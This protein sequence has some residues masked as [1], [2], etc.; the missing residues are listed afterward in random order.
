MSI[1]GVGTATSRPSS[2]TDATR[3]SI[4]IGRPRSRSCSIEVLWAP[5]APAASM[6]RSTSIGKANPE[7]PGDRL[8]LDHHGAGHGA[9]SGVGDDLVRGLP[10]VSAEIGLKERLPQSLTQMSLRMLART[11]ALSPA[12]ASAVGETD[13]PRAPLARGLAE[14]EPVAF[15]VAD[16]AR[17]RDLGGGIDDAAD[18]PVRSDARPRCT[19][20]GSTLRCAVPRAARR[21]DGNTTRAGRSAR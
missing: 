12:A 7:R 5:T 13:D 20:P 2:C 11:G 18:R 19:P 6:R 4:S 3:A 17:R 15:D 10:P 8:R 9:R 14:R 1:A 21:C 16:H